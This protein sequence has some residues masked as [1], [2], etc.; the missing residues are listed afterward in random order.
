MKGTSSILAL[1]VPLMLLCVSLVVVEVASEGTDSRAVT[2]RDCEDTGKTDYPCRCNQ[3]LWEMK[4]VRTEAWD[5]KYGN[6]RARRYVEF[7]EVSGIDYTAGPPQY[8]G[9]DNIC[10]WDGLTAEGVEAQFGVGHTETEPLSC[11]YDDSLS[12]P[13]STSSPC[14]CPPGTMSWIHTSYDHSTG[15]RAG[16]GRKVYSSSDAVKEF[17]CDGS[18]GTQISIP[19]GCPS[20]AVGRY[21][22]YYSNPYRYVVFIYVLFFAS[23]SYSLILR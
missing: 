18:S 2:D 12:G 14:C 11:H 21:N 19:T 7:A 6:Y 16:C 22:P 23:S 9:V 15:C 8:D 5:I 4:C 10:K 13:V 17:E 20:C 1:G 3:V